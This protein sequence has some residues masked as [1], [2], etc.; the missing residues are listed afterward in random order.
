MSFLSKK[1]FLSDLCK[2]YSLP[3]V[4]SSDKAVRGDNEKTRQGAAGHRE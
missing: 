3:V 1:V 2:A 4:V